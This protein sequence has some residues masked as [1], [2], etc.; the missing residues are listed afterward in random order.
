MTDM[1]ISLR[2]IAM[3]GL[4]P[5]HSPLKES[6]EVQRVGFGRL[7]AVAATC[8]VRREREAGGRSGR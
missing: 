3:A 2:I 4:K 7:E 1:I 6:G 5:I 8:N